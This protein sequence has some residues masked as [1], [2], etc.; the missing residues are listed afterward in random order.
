MRSSPPPASMSSFPPSVTT[1]SRWIR[2]Q[3]RRDLR[4][5][6]TWRPRPTGSAASDARGRH[7]HRADGTEQCRRAGDQR[8]TSGV[9]CDL[10]E[11]S[12]G[13]TRATALS[14]LPMPVRFDSS[15]KRR[16]FFVRGCQRVLN[17][18]VTDGDRHRVD[19]SRRAR[20]AT[21]TRA[22]RSARSARSPEARRA[23]RRRRRPWQMGR[24]TGSARSALVDRA[25]RARPP[26]A[27]RSA[28]STEGSTSS[29]RSGHLVGVA[30]DQRCDRALAGVVAIGLGQQRNR[31]ECHHTMDAGPPVPGVI[32]G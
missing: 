18:H 17:R 25:H 19:G 24:T 32:G 7:R 14:T 6:R 15:T 4:C 11:S 29:Y 20:R 9:G 28:T 5:R 26:S 21:P 1:T 22:G 3:R 30:T 2:R 13:S 16:D 8:A 27:R 10:H 12:M 31:G 23:S